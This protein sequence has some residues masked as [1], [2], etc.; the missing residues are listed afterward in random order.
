MD[1][2]SSQILVDTFR[3]EVKF[4]KKGSH[5]RDIET[6][7]EVVRRADAKVLGS[8]WKDGKDWSSLGEFD[9]TMGLLSRREAGIFLWIES[10][11]LSPRSFVTSRE[12]GTP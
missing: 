5:L 10:K 9:L 4:S 3:K 1:E 2:R 8:V 6:T 7:Y 12:A 11:I